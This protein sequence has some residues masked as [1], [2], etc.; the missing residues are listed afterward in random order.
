MDAATC[1]M[2]NIDMGKAY[3]MLN[4]FHFFSVKMDKTLNRFTS[5]KPTSPLAKADRHTFEQKRAAAA[6]NIAT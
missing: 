4:S 5:I 2:T 6:D 3:T 1:K